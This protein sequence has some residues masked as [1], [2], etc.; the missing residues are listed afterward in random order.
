MTRRLWQIHSWVGLVAGIGLLVIGLTGSLLVFRAEL[1]QL[2]NPEY[3]RVSPESGRRQ[4]LDTLRTTVRR[5]LPESEITGWLI[6]KEKTQADLVYVTPHGETEPAIAFVN[7]RN[8]I[9]VGGAKKWNDTFTGWLLDLH[10]SFLAGHAGVLVTGLLAVLLCLLGLTGLWLYRDFWRNFCTLRW[11]ASA[12]ILFSDLHKTVGIS[13]VAFNLLLGFTGAYWNL[14]HALEHYL[15]G[16]DEDPV[17]RQHFYADNLSWDALLARARESIT[18]F[19]PTYLELPTQPQGDI[20]VYGIVP[21]S[22]LRSDYGSSVSFDARSGAPKLITDIRQ[23][24]IWSQVTDAFYPLHFGT[25]GG[26]WV[27]ILWCAGGLSPGLLSV[28]G[29]LIWWNRR[30]R[31]KRKKVPDIP[32][33]AA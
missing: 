27:K 25:F 21:A 11:R 17:V 9:V 10:Y 15:S 3:V 33:P 2:V 5:T 7:P 24:G 29:F 13:T 18:G 16:G 22:P 1:E 26:V 14:P 12:R 31:T 4:P 19:Q 8:G 23:T 6:P 30:P 32:K 28:S 20:I